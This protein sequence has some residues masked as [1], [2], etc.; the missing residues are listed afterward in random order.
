MWQEY[1]QLVKE[2]LI[3]LKEV[4]E[5]SFQG[6]SDLVSFFKKADLTPKNA[7]P[8]TTEKESS[9]EEMKSLFSKIAS[10]STIINQ[11]PNDQAAKQHPI[12]GAEVTIL[13]TCKTT[14]ELNFLKGLA[15]AIDF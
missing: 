12:K 8:Q 9:L 7:T 3:C 10:P 1:K 2:T 4:E 11:I 14:E 6:E 15:R 13:A 5:N